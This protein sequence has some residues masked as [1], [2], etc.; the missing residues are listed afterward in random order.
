MGFDA[1]SSTHYGQLRTPDLHLSLGA[2]H[3]GPAL[4]GNR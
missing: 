2:R 4:A 1:L 3:H